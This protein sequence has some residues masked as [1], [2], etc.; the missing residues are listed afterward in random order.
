MIPYLVM[1]YACF[2]YPLS[3]NNPPLL[4]SWLVISLDIVFLVL[5]FLTS[6]HI[7]NSGFHNTTHGMD[8]YHVF[9]EEATVVYGEINAYIQ[10][11]LYFL[12]LSGTIGLIFLRNNSTALITS[13]L[14]LISSI[15]A[16]RMEDRELVKRIGEVQ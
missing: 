12:L 10:H 7:E 9:S 14:I 16:A 5:F 6:L 11:S 15:V 8:I 4:H 3:V 2:S 13:L 1:W